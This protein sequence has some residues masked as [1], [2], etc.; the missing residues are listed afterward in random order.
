[1]AIIRSLLDQDLYKLTMQQAVI[2]Q[3]PDAEVVYRFVNRDP[4]REIL[5]VVEDRLKREVDEM[6]YLTLTAEDIQFLKRKCPYLYDWYL[7]WL[8]AFSPNPDEVSITS[9]GV[10]IRGPWRTAI[11]WEVPLMATI[12][13]IFFD[14][15]YPVSLADSQTV[16]LS[17]IKA[18][19]LG[20]AAANFA[21]FGTRR[22]RSHEIHRGVLDNLQG[23]DT[24]IGTSNV[25][26]AKEFDLRPIGTMA[27]EWVMGVSALRGLRYANRYAME[28]WQE[29]YRGMLGIALT[30]TYG[31]P[32]FFKDFDASLVRLF[33]GVRQDSGDP[34]EL[35]DRMVEHMTNMRV[36]TPKTII[37]SDGLRS[38]EVIRIKQACDRWE[39]ANINSA[40][41]IGTNLTN[42]EG[43]EDSPPL[44]IVVK[45]FEVNEIPVAKLSDVPEKATGHPDAIREAKYVFLGE[46]FSDV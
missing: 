36:T 3:F 15:L 29:V 6:Q 17:R 16:S 1:M 46:G 28:A 14:E 45:L 20:V 10:E 30:D 21:D 11:Y 19:V 26:F 12:S 18:H 42:D 23:G 38:E 7:D 37:F 5:P 2:R 24:F 22:R 33:D 34:L 31:S 35:V 9:D 44:N 25:A 13:E 41:G 43:I 8:A 32:A 4:G 27:H 40:F 39:G